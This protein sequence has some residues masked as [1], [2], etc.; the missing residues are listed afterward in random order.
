M[1][2][3]STVLIGA[4][5]VAALFAITA[6]KELF[7]NIEEDFSYWASEPVITGFT[8]A[9]SAQ[10]SPAGVQCVP[11]AT[12]AVITLTVR[13]PKNF[14]FVMPGT[15]APADIVRFASGIHDASGTKAPEAG[16]DYTLS[17]SGQ[18]TLTLT[19]KPAFLKRYEQSRANIG[20]S[21][22]LYSTDGRKFNQTY[23]FDL[24]ANTPPPD[25]APVEASAANKI[26]LFKTC[27]PEGG[28]HYYVL[29]FKVDGLPGEN[30]PANVPLHSDLTHVYVSKNGGTETACPVMLNS[31][32]FVITNPLNTAFIAKTDAAPLSNAEADALSGSPQP[33]TVPLGPW[34]LYLKTDVPVGGV[35][36]KYGIRLFDGKF[37]SARAEQTIGKREL[38]APKVFADSTMNNTADSG[39]YTEKGATDASGNNDLNGGGATIGGVLP[40]GS[41][42]AHAIPV[43]SAYGNAV[44]L[45]IKKPDGTDYPAGVTVTGSA[46]KDSGD[47]VPGSASFTAGQSAVVTLPSP[48]DGGGVA[49]YKVVFKATGEGFDDSTTR[50]L[51]YKVRREVKA[52]SGLNRQMWH[53]LKKAIEYTSAG[54]TV[55]VNGEIKAT[56]APDNYDEITINK[57][58]TIRGNNK[59]FDILNA[60]TTDGSKPGHR[61]FSVNFGTLTL[62]NLTLK[63]GICPSGAGGGIYIS[64]NSSSCKMTDTDIKNCTVSG[65]NKLGGAVYVRIDGS[66]IVESGCVISGNTA[67]DGKGAAVYLESGGTF[68]IAGDAQINEAND[69]FLEKNADVPYVPSKNAKLTVTAPLTGTHIVARITPD[70]YTAGIAAVNASGVDIS[71]YANRFKI[72]DQNPTTPWKLIHN[73]TDLVLKQVTTVIPSGSNAWKTLKNAIEAS[74]VEDGD[75]FVIQGAITATSATGDHGAISVTKKI[76][77]KGAGSTPTLDADTRS[78]IFT[79]ENGGELTLENLTLKKGKADGTQDADKYGGG[80]LVKEGCEAKL[81]NCTVKACAAAEKG[82]GICSFGKLTLDGSTIGGASA[83]DGNKAKNGGGIFL[84]GSDAA[85]TMTGGKISYNEARR[86]DSERPDG[87]GIYIEQSASFTMKSGEISNNKSENSNSIVAYGG[88]VY[89]KGQAG[90]TSASFTLENGTIKN[91]TAYFGGGVVLNNGGIFNMQGGTIEGNHAT[92]GGGVGVQGIMKMAGGTI[93][94][95]T[96]SGHGKGVYVSTSQRVIEMS[97]SAKID[98]DNDVYLDG[99]S[100]SNAKITVDGTLNPLGGIA[101]RITPKNYSETPPVQV[102][103]GSEVGSEHGKFTVTPKGNEYWTVDSNGYLTN[104]KTVIFNN[105]TKD[106][107]EA[108]IK[109]ADPSMIYNEGDKIDHMALDG[110]LVLYM[111]GKRDY[112]IMHVTEVN[113]GGGGYIKFNYKTFRTYNSDVL[114]NSGKVVNGGTSFDLDSG[115]SGSSGNDFSLKNTGQKRFKVLDNAKF[116]ILPN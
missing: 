56:N 39:V 12:D 36:A 66:L 75:E 113:N 85:C 4:A 94:G 6:C 47:S 33:D 10:T 52:V 46:E 71:A 35:T 92:N 16:T 74:T 84:T 114:Q 78:R 23:S 82:G 90:G 38:P 109:A 8:A 34:V 43:Y 108:A 65:G 24:E 89:V 25:P 54:G 97:G 70:D 31:G 64:N 105:I 41:D 44:K 107:I 104:N 80:I 30:V 63:G 67:P 40:D 22:T 42:V 62:K 72:T 79:V 99:M 45:T 32:D 73:G 93:S 87:G 20:A 28:K 53:I 69:V 86:T 48:A 11:S 19:Y 1:R 27:T 7:A 111:T 61:I 106:Q 5:S 101:A 76:T 3:F 15:G 91:N 14:S 68:N 49:V 100:S 9:S 96:A 17:Q 50:T 58:L 51:Y 103:T 37:Y 57:N 13:N 95:N 59:T 18:S 21:I 2:K 98:T 83:S 116:Y 60:N 112:G 55:V 77:V 81:K 29:C 115:G 102:L 110:K 88:G 26:A